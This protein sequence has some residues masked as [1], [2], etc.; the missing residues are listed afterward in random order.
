MFD[1]C[2]AHLSKQ[3]S[4]SLS[5]ENFKIAVGNSPIMHCKRLSIEYVMYVYGSCLFSLILRLKIYI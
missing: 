1:Y 4:L 2:K 5:V 3:L